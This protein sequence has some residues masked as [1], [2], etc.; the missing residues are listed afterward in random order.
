MA[1]AQ[2]VSE[3]TVRRVCQR[4]SLKPHLTKTFKLSGGK[5]FVEK[6]CDVVGLYLNPS[7][8]SLVQA[9]A[10]KFPHTERV[11]RT[12]GD[13]SLRIQSFKVPDH[14]Q[15]EVAAWRQ[16]RWTHGRRIESN[17][18]LFDISVKVGLVEHSIQ[19][20]IERVRRAPGQFLR[21]HP[22]IFLLRL[23]ILLSHCHECSV[24]AWSNNFDIQFP[25]S[26]TFTTRC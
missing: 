6:L 21:C 5:Q 18:L 10:Q 14:Q 7:D 24:T 3:A 12:P 22:H 19:A 9:Q 15:S 8:K 13:S 17:A 16:T 4:H 1:E 25:I 20:L 23:L 2:G 11:G 26:A